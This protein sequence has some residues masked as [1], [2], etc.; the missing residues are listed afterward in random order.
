MVLL[1]PPVQAISFTSMD[2]TKS[3]VMGSVKPHLPQK[4]MRMMSEKTRQQKARVSV[5][6]CGLRR[7]GPRK[8]LWRSRVI[9]RE[10][11]QAVHALK[12]AKS[13]SKLEQVFETR[14]SRLLKADL[15]DTLA[16]LQRQNE[17]ELA[18]KVF[19]YLKNEVWYRPDP[20][21]Y[22]NM[23]QTL[24]KNK[25]IEF[26]EEL[27]AGLEKEGLKPDTRTFTEMIGA[28]FQVGEIG[29]AIE[30]YRKLKESSCVPDKLTFTILIRNLLKAGEE[31]LAANL[32]KE[33]A[34]YIDYPEKFLEEIEQKHPR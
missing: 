5:I 3:S 29:K 6:T 16:E 27:F 20:S 32:K 19:E 11:I 26:A 10:A 18:I 28:Y 33:C 31:E 25:L 1:F 7:E 34:K 12:L 22:S 13:D 23:I 24:G 4:M 21:L 9:S 30:T 2:M 8:P 14:L 17:L 15:L